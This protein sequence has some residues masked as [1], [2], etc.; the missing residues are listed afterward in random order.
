MKG[1]EIA[2]IDLT[3][4]VNFPWKTLNRLVLIFSINGIDAECMGPKM[5]KLIPSSSSIIY[6]DKIH[7][8]PRETHET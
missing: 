6:K 4:F 7:F 5:N 8:L 3:L 2:V 1:H